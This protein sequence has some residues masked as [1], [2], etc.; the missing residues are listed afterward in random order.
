[1]IWYIS[2]ARSRINMPAQ[3]LSWLILATFSCL[4]QSSVVVPTTTTVVHSRLI[5]MKHESGMA[6]N[7]SFACRS[8]ISPL[9]PRPASKSNSSHLDLQHKQTP[10]QLTTIPYH[11]TTFI[12]STIKLVTAAS[13]ASHLHL[14]ATHA[15]THIHHITSHHTS[16]LLVRL[17]CK[18]MHPSTHHADLLQ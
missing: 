15:N 17:P 6:L 13:S 1:M 9:L 16:W 5:D 18:R 11:T 14:S 2:L 4:R 10:P 12:L 7:A 3:Q 8:P